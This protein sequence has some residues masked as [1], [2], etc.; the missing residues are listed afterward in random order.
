MEDAWQDLGKKSLIR[1]CSLMK[2]VLFHTMV[3][4]SELG[5][6]N[7]L[8]PWKL[9]HHDELANSSTVEE[10]K[11]VL[12]DIASEICLVVKG[13]NDKYSYPIM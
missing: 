12:H 10:T 2:K 6:Y 1:D 3:E 8:K 7:P 11:K 4:N 5:F 9:F 13:Q